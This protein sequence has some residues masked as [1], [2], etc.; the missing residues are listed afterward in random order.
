MGGRTQLV[1]IELGFLT[2][3]RYIVQC[4]YDYVVPF[5]PF[6]GGGCMNYKINISNT[7]QSSCAAVTLV[8]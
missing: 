3:N 1:F 2:S 5:A 7:C 4:L 8:D 6:V